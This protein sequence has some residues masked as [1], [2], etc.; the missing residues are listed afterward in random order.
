[1]V[2]NAVHTSS[3][4]LAHMV[5]LNPFYSVFLLPRCVFV[6]TFVFLHV[7]LLL[8]DV[9]FPLFASLL[10]IL[11]IMLMFFMLFLFLLIFLMPPFFYVLW[12]IRI[13]KGLFLSFFVGFMAMFWSLF[14]FLGCLFRGYSDDRFI[15]FDNSFWNFRWLGFRALGVHWLYLN[16]WGL[17]S[18]DYLCGNW[19]K[20]W[21]LSVNHCR[22]GLGLCLLL[23]GL[24]R[25][26]GRCRG[27]RGRIN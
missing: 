20:D 2:I 13:R 3:L 8:L 24:E 15:R 5:T 23:G 4:F 7:F 27:I 21:K 9:A 12:R 14:V 10:H 17:S 22:F 18:D 11:F 25:L 1:M 6:L 26:W 16:H 19:C